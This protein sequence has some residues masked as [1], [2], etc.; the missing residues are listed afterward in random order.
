MTKYFNTADDV[1]MLNSNLGYYYAW[2]T[3]KGYRVEEVRNGE[4]SPHRYDVRYMLMGCWNYL[5]SIWPADDAT[6]ANYHCAFDAGADP[7]SDGWR[8]G[9]GNVCSKHGWGY[10]TSAYDD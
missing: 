5:G 4:S 7:I 8:D 2:D 6:C 1:N 10:I 9:I 3:D